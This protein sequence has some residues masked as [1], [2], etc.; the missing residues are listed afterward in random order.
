LLGWL[1]RGEHPLLTFLPAD[2]PARSDAAHRLARAL[3][4]RVERG[5]HRALLI[6]SVDGVEASRSPLAPAFVAAGFTATLRGLLKRGP[7]EPAA[8]D[9]EDAASPEAQG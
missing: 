9:T 3:A 2:E 4:E 6:A 7:G 1:G 5:K 8:G